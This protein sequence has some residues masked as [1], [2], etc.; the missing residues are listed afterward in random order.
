MAI[1]NEKNI[2]KIG[3]E[4]DKGSLKLSKVRHKSFIRHHYFEGQ[5]DFMKRL[6]YQSLGKF[7][8]KLN[9]NEVEMEEIKHSLAHAISC[10]EGGCYK[11]ISKYYWLL[12]STQIKDPFSRS[13]RRFVFPDFELLATTI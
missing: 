5:Y 9:G 13:Y 10:S 3:S 6:P 7:Y 2:R 12:T 8:G 11:D 4:Q 1:F